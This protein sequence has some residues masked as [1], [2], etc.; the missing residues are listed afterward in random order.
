MELT[1]TTA[2]FV[3]TAFHQ[4]AIPIVQEIRLD[5]EGGEALVDLTLRVSSE[6]P[7]TAP[8]V[9]PIDRVEAGAIRYVRTPDLRLD[10]GMLRNLTE[11]VRA[12]LLVTAEANGVEVARHEGA[13][14]LLPP[15]H[16]G[17]VTA[18]P[19]LLAAF[20][21]P[22]DPAVDAVLHEAAR[23]LAAAA[24]PA[25]IDGY[26]GGTR[27]RVWELAGAIWA[28]LADLGITY[29]LPPAS[30]ER[31]GQ[32]VRGPAD[33]MARRT[34]TCL[35][36][37][38]F[39]AACLEQ[40]GL[41]PLVVLTHGHA[42]VG[43]WLQRTEF[44]DAV[45]DDAQVLRK[46]RDLQDLVLVETTY[47]TQGIAGRFA[48]AVERGSAQ[49]DD[50][51]PAPLELAVDV[52]RARMRRI[53]PLDLGEGTGATPLVVAEGAAVAM[54]L[55]AA[56][57]FIEEAPPAA[58]APDDRVTDRLERWKRRL[59]DL[60]LRNKLLNFKDATKA[61]PLDVADAARF[62]DLLAEGRKF[63]L[64][65]RTDVLSDGDGRSAALYR[66][67]SGED[68]RRAYLAQSLEAGDAHTA[69]T[70]TELDGRLLELHRLTKTAFEEGGSNILFLALGF[71]TWTQGSGGRASRAP[72]ILVPVSLARSS[73][74]AGFRLALHDEEARFNPTLLEMLRQDFNLKLP[75]FERELP[76]DASGVAVASVWQTLR[77]HVRDLK[78][79]EVTGEVVLSTFSFTKFLMWKDLVER[80]DQLKESP[81][82][83]HLVDTPKQSY[84]DASD[85]PDARRLD[86]DYHPRDIFAPLS[87]D[88]SQLAAVM[89][90]DR[91]KDFVLF[92]PPG[93]GKSQT[94]A[95]IIAQC[96]ASGRTVLFVSQ[97]TA[98]LEVVQR[99]LQEIGLG[100][101]CLEIHS[102]KA[103]KTAVLAR[104][105]A[106]W[107][108]RQAPTEG[109]WEAATADLGALRDELNGLVAALHRRHPNGLT[110]FDAFGRV[111]RG[112]E[113]PDALRLSWPAGTSHAAEDLARLRHLCG[114]L[115]TACRA[116]G[117]PAGHPL[118]GV[119]QSEW[120]PAWRRD[121]GEA[122]ATAIA[123]LPTLGAAA[124]ALL[125]ALNLSDLA[126][127][128]AGIAAL[129]AFADTLCA[130]EAR[131]G[132]TLLAPGHARRRE[133][134]TRLLAL[135][136]E[137]VPLRASLAGDYAPTV[138]GL[139]LSEIGAQW[140]AASA[141]NFLARGGRQKAVR[142]LLAPHARGEV[143]ADLGPD[144]TMLAGLGKLIATTEGLAPDLASLGPL[145]AGLATDAI[146]LRAAMAWAE[147]ARAASR[148]FADASGIAAPALVDYL[149][150]LVGDYSDLVDAGGDI[151]L[152]RDALA[153]AWAEAEPTVARLGALAGRPPEAPLPASG[154]DWLAGST[155]ALTRWAASLH[156]AQPW[157]YWARTAR[158][159]RASGLEPIVA[160][161]ENGS[162]APDEAEAA[163]ELAYA[164][165]W[166]DGIVT[167][168]PVLRGFLFERHED[169]IDRY[170]RADERVGALARR[171]VRTRLRGDV[172]PPTAF[173]TDPEWG[174][175]SRELTKKARHM[176]LRNLFRSLPTALTRLTPCLM[177]SPLSIAQYLPPGSRPFDVVIFDEASQI[178]AWDA[179]G[180]LARGRQAIVVGDPEQL[181]PTNVGDR[182]ID[183]VE[184]GTDVEDQESIL[185]EC[186]ASNIPSRRL[187]WHYRSKRESLIAFANHAYYKGRLVTFPAAET[188]DRAVHLV[189]VPGG[190][191]LRG[192]ARTN[193]AEARAVV[194][195]VVRRLTDPVF[196]AGSLS[197]GVI[198]FNGQ[199]QRLIEN[200]LDAERRSHPKIEIFFDAA[201]WHEP[202]FVK[203]LENV[204]GDERDVILFSVTFAPEPD[205][206]IGT[207]SSLNRDGGHRRLNVAITRARREMAVFATL[208]PDQISLTG[209]GAR[210][211]RDFKH[212]LEFAERGPR[213]LAEAAAPL[214]R[215]TDSPFEDAVKDELERRGWQVH[216]QVGV[217]SFRIDLGVVHPDAPG[218]YLA[219][220]EC[221]GATYHR[222]ATARD[223]DRLRETILRGLGWR[224]RRVWSTDWWI[225]AATAANRLH[226]GLSADLAE[227]RA[228]AAE[229]EAARTAPV[230]E[231]VVDNDAFALSEP[232]VLPA[233]EGAAPFDAAPGE[234][235]DAE[236]ALDPLLA[237]HLAP[238]AEAPRFYAK[239]PAHLVDG[240]G[241]G[242]F[243]R[244][245][246][247]E[248]GL[249][250][251][252]ERFY[253]PAYRPT[254]RAMVAHVVAVEGP[255]F[256]DVVVGR[257]SQAHGFGR[258]GGKIRD[259]IEASVRPE[260]VRTLEEGR[261][262][263]WPA[264]SV[265][266]APVPFRP[267]EPGERDHGDISLA[268]LAG[269]A[270]RHAALTANPEEVIRLMAGALGL[271]RLRDAARMRLHVAY[272][273]GQSA[274]AEP[275]ALARP[276]PIQTLDEG[277][278]S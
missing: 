265:P 44:A 13:I 70:E 110:A 213:A 155:I 263:L 77:T 64:L 233:M 52:R 126:L 259:A 50:D 250:V 107:H 275:D 68:G 220:I 188:A 4:N 223:R 228:R 42:L 74:R 176:P 207:I 249:A 35:D 123:N 133:A 172:P 146:R 202:V 103:Q 16:W 190:T 189:P 82:V 232:I 109:D 111:V 269:L 105:K 235:E 211:V 61:V 181:P 219:G 237:V 160:A 21:R 163:F 5:N 95:N 98:A 27:T 39:F 49:V 257:I 225:D 171:I 96:L 25:A 33:I 87:A 46:R 201:R 174:T 244:A 193:E 247:G 31:T 1:C 192:K 261:T 258:I 242:R 212:F 29:V 71:L 20:V 86:V 135:T 28:A 78:G 240:A 200:L 60:S 230:Q 48:A 143:P 196:A 178:P 218:R 151:R 221:D 99:R 113:K 129:L 75:E 41:D 246:P 169:A 183:E 251:E 175:L 23:K 271:G 215:D 216:P 182:G 15:S 272:H 2:A 226:D 241:T 40:A 167:D 36:T 159:A 7:V 208:R 80:I 173:G 106:A 119:E 268:E 256:L 278:A 149:R 179:I 191:Y 9:V 185:D 114:E 22:N 66:E 234:G 102:A 248:C 43:L 122:I 254:L 195:E 3:N 153:R 115:A 203:N 65:P 53:R 210:G 231:A 10:A 51:A 112:R 204:Q 144:L 266:G 130:P 14:E 11:G 18:A 84:G 224:I 209:A 100:D 58:P 252:P 164:R 131:D 255:V 236:P 97:K 88:S 187:E 73:V 101:H 17:G 152:A 54:E 139:D 141:S 128:R 81:V 140:R 108:D 92:G 184:D 253:D 274:P 47:L 94:I 148:A 127:D 262:L 118:R 199:Q 157:C 57:A 217:S 134:C 45:I 238:A 72:I 273:I 154:P 165:W 125:A 245:E 222:S 85:F 117:A 243:R 158:E 30:F 170:R 166:A 63:R 34:A 180:A 6:P 38:L 132:L 12:D 156:R 214:D 121:F 147:S 137:A 161:L 69:L 260:I 91:G 270:L 205:G 24:R 90:A 79:W 276:D 206:K 138:F 229:V 26:A 37:A 76:T 142:A 93:T 145:W 150:Q 124:E 120:S 277:V 32:K 177:M 83:R 62:E 59:L 168:D 89:A 56:P 104:L 67:R 227:D 267:A 162:V 197:L 136:D 8:L 198:T 116:V 55:D 264:G 194:A 186:L 239:P 19:E